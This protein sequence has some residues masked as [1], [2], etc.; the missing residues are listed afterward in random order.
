M[1]LAHV[2]HRIATDPSFTTQF[3]QDP[4]KALAD[5]QVTL[6]TESIEV[7]LAILR[8]NPNWPALCSP[9]MDGPE[10]FPWTG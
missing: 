6:D 8:T 10:E 9:A 3:L 1:T 4:P 2:V 5:V 7:L